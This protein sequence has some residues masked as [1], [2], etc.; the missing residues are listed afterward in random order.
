[1]TW[2]CIHS[3]GELYL[4][5]HKQNSTTF[6]IL[7]DVIN[8]VCER[9]CDPNEGYLERRTLTDA[10]RAF[11]WL[12]EVGGH[13]IHIPGQVLLSYI[14]KQA[15]EWALRSKPC[16]PAVPLHQSLP[17]FPG[18]GTN[19]LNLLGFGHSVSSSIRNPSQDSVF[20]SVVFNHCSDGRAV[21]LRK[22]LKGSH[23]FLISFR[24][25]TNHNQGPEIAI[26]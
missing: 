10:C 5:D 1:M 3:S 8:C 21:Y 18:Q 17:D 4:L 22:L 14:R 7:T 15:A 11:S 24:R 2:F 9:F 26:F 20:I 12:K 16:W 6:Q 13:S 19:S 25:T 23:C